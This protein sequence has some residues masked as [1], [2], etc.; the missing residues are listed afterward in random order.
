RAPSAA[1]IAAGV[2]KDAQISMILETA[3]IK[4]GTATAGTVGLSEIKVWQDLNGE[5]N[6]ITTA[7]N[8]AIGVGY[9]YNETLYGWQTEGT[10]TVKDY[11][12][13]VDKKGRSIADVRIN[14]SWT[15][16]DGLTYA[17]TMKG[18]DTYKGTR[19]M[20]EVTSTE[21]DEKYDL[22]T[23]W[24]EIRFEGSF[25][26]DTAT[27]NADELLNLQFNYV[28]ALGTASLNDILEYSVK[29]SEFT[30]STAVDYTVTAK[31]TAGTYDGIEYKAGNYYFELRPITVGALEGET[32]WICTGSDVEGQKVW[33]APSAAE[34]A[35]GIPEDAQ[36]SMILESADLAAGSATAGTVGLSEIKVWQTI[37]N[38]DA[39]DITAAYNAFVGDK[40]DL[41]EILIEN[42]LSGSVS[43]KN[44]SKGELF[45]N[46]ALVQYSIEGVNGKFVGT[47][48]DDLAVSTVADESF[49]LK[50]SSLWGHD[51]AKFNAN[52][53]NDTVKVNKEE[54]IDLSF[55]NGTATYTYEVSGKDLLF[56]ANDTVTL[57]ATV[58]E[59]AKVDGYDVAAGEY[60][61]ELVKSGSV[62]AQP[63]K[64]M[65]QLTPN[66]NGAEAAE[67]HYVYI[68]LDET[69]FNT[70]AGHATS[71]KDQ[72]FPVTATTNM[73]LTNLQLVHTYSDGTSDTGAVAADE[74]YQGLVT[75]KG[76]GGDA[77]TYAEEVYNSQAVGT[78][79]VKDYAAKDTGATLLVNNAAFNFVIN[80]GVDNVEKGKLNGSVANDNINVAAYDSPD[81]VKGVTINSGSG[82]DNIAGSDYNDA[83]TAKSLAG[84]RA[85]VAENSG[86]NKITTDKGD[87]IIN[88]GAGV[89]SNTIKTGEGADTVNIAAGSLGVNKITGGKGV[90]T[91]AAH[92]VAL[93]ALT[94]GPGLT[95]IG[96]V[97][98]DGG[99]LVDY[100]GVN[101]YNLNGGINTLT[102]K[103]VAS[104]YD[105]TGALVAGTADY[106]VV[107]GDSSNKITT[108]AGNDF[109]QVLAAA[110]NSVNNI[111]TGAG[112]DS[113]WLNG[114]INTVDSGA[115][116]D[117]FIINNG[118]N[119]IKSGAGNDTFTITAGT[120]RID[121][122]AGDD[123][124]TVTGGSSSISGGAGDDIY[125]AR[126]LNMAANYLGINDTKGDNE[127]MI[128]NK[129]NIF[130][131]VAIKTDK[132][133]AL[134][135][136]ATGN[137]ILFTNA[138]AFTG[139][140]GGT[141]GVQVEVGKNGMDQI[142]VGLTKYSLDVSDI[143]EAVA[144]W[145]AAG[146]KYASAAE[147]FEQ[148]NA[149]DVAALTALYVGNS[150][151]CYQ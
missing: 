41:N 49:D 51:T 40:Y 90:V 72:A 19:L 150:A 140:N 73:T 94:F 43:V 1:E 87:D 71:I 21:A 128:S 5:L 79:L 4:A 109:V 105:K 28:D 119:N 80:Q 142:T 148:N 67:K 133:G 34:I 78:V 116:D 6:N 95:P 81:G 84:Q 100:M 151:D 36:I 75:A 132:N 118:K 89:T 32:A 114:G 135:S 7:Y 65:F 126:G 22:G 27:L 99:L 63:N 59:G 26:K 98:G 39:T 139:F 8:A 12:K 86:E 11:V 33:R 46:N 70:T 108:G 17:P 96:V 37:N 103:S 107:G 56:K 57:K 54:N 62:G 115:G 110:A 55:G 77:F 125:D 82:N 143:T 121:A 149:A 66:Y 127:I 42:Q 112:D 24:D 60:T 31:L 69:D 48:I 83:V 97:D 91:N 102:S 23:G 147:V 10:V 113:L 93:N 61:L 117:L 106:V 25:G 136:V 138:G 14:N 123:V 20:E 104:K 2:D 45:V 76:L 68:Y 146:G 134:K 35:A 64:Y 53:G 50:K 145:L 74:Y 120:N 122:G 129:A 101:Q 111:K 137:Q 130:F 85:T 29:G 141:N 3:D 9:E 30:V 52:F 124:F 16:L 88:I 144:G 58:S 92:E 131:D 15:T 13:N 44:Y 18:K 47:D 38:G